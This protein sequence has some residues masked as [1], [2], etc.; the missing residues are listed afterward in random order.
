MV[1]VAVME[2]AVAAVKAARCTCLRN[3]EAVVADDAAVGNVG[4][5]EEC[6]FSAAGL[7]LPDRLKKKGDRIFKC[8]TTIFT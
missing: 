8:H 3:C 6:L 5:A 2:A 4:S 1:V 7:C